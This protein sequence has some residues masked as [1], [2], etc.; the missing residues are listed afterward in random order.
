MARLTLIVMTWLVMSLPAYAASADRIDR[1]AE[2]LGLPDMIEVMQQ[3]GVSYGQD[4]ALDMFPSRVSANWNQRLDA[5]YDQAWMK[6]VVW[7]GLGA[8]LK[9]EDIA[10][11]ETFFES[12]L[13]RQIVALEVSARRALMDSEIEEATKLRVADMADAND[14]RLRKIDEFIAANSLLENN[15]VGALNSN[16]AF[17]AALADGGA[18]DGALSEAQILADVWSQEEEIR[19]DTREWLHAFLVMA[20][21]PLDDSDLDAYIALSETP[22]GRN[23][24]NALFAAFDGMFEEISRALGQ[25]A[26]QF[27]TAQDL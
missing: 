22:A 11:L 26:A 18:F 4:L 15:I 1:L 6:D 5:I 9:D 20:Y 2:L 14:A 10:P 3:E 24:N 17:Y 21:Q 12:D 19:A 8:A 23:L 7:A 13:G 25:S 16:F 27:M